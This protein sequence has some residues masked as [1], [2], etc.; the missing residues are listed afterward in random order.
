MRLFPNPVSAI[1]TVE[2]A[3]GK[4]LEIVNTLGQIVIKSANVDAKNKPFLIDISHLP[5]G[6]YFVRMGREVL[7]FVKK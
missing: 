7:Y 3:E 6:V 1:L 4:T 2:N 5:S